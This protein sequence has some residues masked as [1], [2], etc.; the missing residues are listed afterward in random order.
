MNERACAV[1]G[2]VRDR[3]DG[4]GFDVI[5]DVSLMTS[6]WGEAERSTPDARTPVHG[7]TDA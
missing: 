3:G 1:E 7:R 5:L 6:T 2:Q 4:S